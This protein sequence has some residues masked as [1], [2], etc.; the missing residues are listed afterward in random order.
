MVVVDAMV[1]AYYCQGEQVRVELL[2]D[3]AVVDSQTLAASS[4]GV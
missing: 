3:G 2:S 1:T 4:H